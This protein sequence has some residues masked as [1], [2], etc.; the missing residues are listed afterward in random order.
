MDNVCDPSHAEI[1]DLIRLLTAD[2]DHMQ[3]QGEAMHSGVASPEVI[4]EL[5][6]LGYL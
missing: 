2:F 4:E 6:A 1:A 3:T 5:K